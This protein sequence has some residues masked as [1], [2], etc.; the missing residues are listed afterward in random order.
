MKNSIIFFSLLI[1]SNIIGYVFNVIISKFWDKRHKHHTS[2]SKKEVLYSLLILLINI[3]IA[4]PG[5]ILWQ[6]DIITFSSDNFLISFIAL[7]ILMDFLMY[8]LHWCSHNIPYLNKF[9]A[10]HHEHT[11]EFNAVS[12]YYM[13]LWEAVFFGLLL[14]IVSIVF[15]FN[16]Y[17]F[18]VFLVFNWLYGVITHLNVK[19]NVNIKTAKKSSL[20]FT[21]NSFHQKHHQLNYYNYGFYT[22]FWDEVFKT[23]K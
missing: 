22:V 3:L 13:S 21:T 8:V 1:L 11:I 4:I 19:K 14:T 5:Y 12:L 9:H 10:K 6:I 7:F 18:I 15:S 23:A 20:L 2:T 16:L 17:S